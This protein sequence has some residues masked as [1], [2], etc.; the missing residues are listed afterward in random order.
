[1][2][3]YQN[4]HRIADDAEEKMI[5]KAMQVHSAQIALAGGKRF[6]VFCSRK[7]ETP[8]LVVEIGRKSRISDPLVI[9]HDL[10]DIGTNLR[11][12]DQPHHRRRARIC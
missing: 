6:R 10:M 8:R 11:M 1:M 7:H 4:P 3:H 2:S 9:F 12:Q 5:R